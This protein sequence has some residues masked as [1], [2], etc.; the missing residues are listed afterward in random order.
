MLLNASVSVTTH[1]WRYVTCLWWVEHER[2][3]GHSDIQWKKSV[4][5]FSFLWSLKFKFLLFTAA[6][7]AD[8]SHDVLLKRTD[9][10]E[11]VFCF[12]FSVSWECV[13]VCISVCVLP[14]LNLIRQFQDYHGDNIMTNGSLICNQGL[15][16]LSLHNQSQQRHWETRKW[17]H[18]LGD[19]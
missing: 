4:K 6:W 14:N 1:R 5:I 15:M 9:Q 3:K 8:Q 13:Y 10:T 2:R 7:T 12:S 16:S 18:N 11:S 19:K 17:E